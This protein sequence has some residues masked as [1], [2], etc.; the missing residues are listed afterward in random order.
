[1]GRMLQKHLCL[2]QQKKT[3]FSREIENIKRASYNAFYPLQ[4]KHQ[5]HRELQ[6]V[7]MLCTFKNKNKLKVMKRARLTRDQ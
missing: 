3:N 4:N 2:T 5:I 6:C 1:M 7:K